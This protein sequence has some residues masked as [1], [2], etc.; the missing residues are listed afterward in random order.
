MA[1]ASEWRGVIKANSEPGAKEDRVDE[2]MVQAEIDHEPPYSMMA[3]LSPKDHIEGS[4]VHAR[5]QT[6]EQTLW[7]TRFEQ[8][9][10]TSFEQHGTPALDNKVTPALGRGRSLPKNGASKGA[11]PKAVWYKVCCGHLFALHPTGDVNAPS[12]L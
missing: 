6:R 4:N 10:N 5:N 7:N 12:W 3:N 8:F 9:G 1:C 2:H 11:A